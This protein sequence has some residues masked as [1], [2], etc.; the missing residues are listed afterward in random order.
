MNN[1]NE[2][3]KWLELA[4]RYLNAETS[5]E[6]E[7]ELLEYYTKTNDSLTLE[8]EDVRKLLKYE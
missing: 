1:M 8:E 2:R 7:L 4:N 3:Q 5:V 6:E